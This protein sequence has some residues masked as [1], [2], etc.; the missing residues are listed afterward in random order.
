MNAAGTP[1]PGELERKYQVEWKVGAGT[2]GVVYKAYEKSSGKTVAIK[3]FKTP[4]KQKEGCSEGISLTACREMM[5]RIY[6]LFMV[7]ILTRLASY[8]EKSTKKIVCGFQ[9]LFYTPRKVFYF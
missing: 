3:L 1:F 8:S 5:V 9:I 4:P 7:I 6:S 2:Y